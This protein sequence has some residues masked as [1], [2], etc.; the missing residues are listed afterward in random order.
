MAIKVG[1]FGAGGKMGSTVC[2]AVTAAP[3]RAASQRMLVFLER[4]N[5]F[6]VPLDEERHSYRLHELF[7]EAL[8]AG[9]E[10]Y[11]QAM[12]TPKERMGMGG[13]A[14]TSPNRPA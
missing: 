6:V 3:T 7:R 1:V 2:Q 14:E 11:L 13:S 12:R 8:L 4:A 5:L 9:S 10:A